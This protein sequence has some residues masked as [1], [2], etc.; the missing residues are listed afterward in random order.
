MRLLAHSTLAAIMAATA[1]PAAGCSTEPEAE[2][3]Q[4]DTN[5][6]PDVAPVKPRH[7]EPQPGLVV[8][9]ETV[10]SLDPGSS[11]EKDSDPS[12]LDEAEA[13][14][15]GA[16]GDGN[17]SGDAVAGAGDLAEDAGDRCALLETSAGCPCAEDSECPSDRCVEG[18]DGGV[19]AVPCGEACPE[20]WSCA[21]V[22]A[23]EDGESELCL[24]RNR[25][26][27]RPCASHEDC[28]PPL[29]E[30]DS[31]C[32][33]HG[34]EGR[35]CASPCEPTRGG[36][37]ND[38][39]CKEVLPLGSAET[40]W[41]CV[42]STGPCTCD[43]PSRAQALETDC[44]ARVERGYCPGVRSCGPEGLSEC[45][46]N[47]NAP[48]CPGSC[49]ARGCDE[50]PGCEPEVLPGWCLV[51]GA[52]Y[53]ALAH[54]P[55]EQCLGCMPEQSQSTWSPLNGASC[56]DSKP[57]TAEDRCHGATCVGA[58]YSCE[59]GLPC[60]DTSCLGDGT[61][62]TE[63]AQGWCYVSDICLEPGAQREGD[64][65][66]AC[67]PDLSS[68]TFSPLTGGACDD[69]EPC[70]SADACVEGSCEGQSYGCDDGLP[71]TSDSCDGEGG[72]VHD[73][74]AGWCL[75][76]GVCAADGEIK[77]GDPCLW[78]R[79]EVEVHMWTPTDDAPCDD[80]EA[81][82]KDD[83]CRGSSCVGEPYACDDGVPCTFDS[84]LGDGTCA[85]P[86]AR[87]TCLI[88]GLC[89]A[90]GSKHPDSPCKGCRPAFA[91]DR[92][93]DLMG[94][95][96]DDGDPCTSADQCANAGCAGSPYSCDDGLGCT[97][98]A[99]D[100]LGGC[101]HEIR[102][103]SCLVDGAC[104]APDAPDPD[105]PCS[106]CQPSVS[107]NA[108]APVSGNT[109]QHQDAC[110]EEGACVEG[111]C[112]PGPPVDCDDNN[113]C[114][115][116]HCDPFV[117]CFHLNNLLPCDDGDSCTA[118]D[119]CWDGMCHGQPK[120]C[121][122]GESCYLGECRDVEAA[123]RLMAMP[124]MDL[125]KPRV[126]L[127]SGG[128]FT[129]FAHGQGASTSGGGL[130]H[131]IWVASYGDDGAQTIDP[132]E[133][134]GAG[135]A[136]LDWN[137]AATR[138]SEGGFM[139]SW[140]QTGSGGGQGDR[141][142]VL[143]PVNQSLTPGESRVLTLGAAGFAPVTLDAQGD[144]NA[145]AMA[146]LGDGWL[147]VFLSNRFVQNRCDQTGAWPVMTSSNQHVFARFETES[148]QGTV[149]L[150]GT[151]CLGR[152]NPDNKM[153]YSQLN[154]TARG[155]TLPML[156]SQRVDPDGKTSVRLDW[157][158]EQGEHGGSLSTTAADAL[159]TDPIAVGGATSG[160]L[161]VWSEVGADG[162]EAGIV[163]LPV[164]DT[165]HAM[166]SEQIVVNSHTGGTQIHPW[167]VRTGEGVV[168]LWE[169]LWQ[170]GSAGGVYA[171]RLIQGDDGSWQKRGDEE[172]INIAVNGAQAWPGA[173]DL[174][175][176]AF[177]VV[178]EH[179]VGDAK[180]EVH[181]RLMRW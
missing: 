154:A 36:C 69:G 40:V 103:E 164:S 123:T 14:D 32:L 60:T 24:P 28:R 118:S 73:L 16:P 117:G 17:A 13:G 160:V 113:A 77:A 50:E 129:V 140:A 152:N 102:A 130:T 147:A 124:E 180:S 158:N 104:F 167:A 151:G 148:S 3:T 22:E 134:A 156:A 68:D 114:T 52:C 159:S 116:D 2:L 119:R 27:C 145:S 136:G 137:R 6:L 65:C 19:C 81:C 75:I 76:G 7:Q 141:D 34:V 144:Q 82:T 35:F 135:E 43:A 37:P 88:D 163:A 42:P 143:R 155:G 91:S 54:S 172:R 99:C 26:L 97:A 132:V 4:Q 89:V 87:A 128:G 9:P 139:V 41:Q 169:S 31:Y 5:A 72:C 92:W 107:V 181:G 108:F 51:E 80:G 1:L 45:A 15:P 29:S 85:H 146:P 61:C 133:V 12:G 150:T 177:V 110:R 179:K 168:V 98:D 100:S 120:S 66:H 178:W 112:V 161:L 10:S 56:D 166:P 55:S 64:P 153:G 96:C 93:V 44:F 86:V 176:G 38:Y 126:L 122:S 94:D 33:D 59:D 47:T 138:R 23:G 39:T 101:T 157:W 121:A 20:E 57:C 111:T 30:G 49:T 175:D 90:G 149:Q 25:R 173:A 171:Q 165:W 21:T 11:G 62:A 84:C 8:L 105:N 83:R 174:G 63:I 79:A 74:S 70:T 127:G 48:S 71:C 115:D 58:S 18:A 142:V 46:P 125:R 78:C 170:D 162:N 106:T 95:P 53:P 67:R 131:G 109:C